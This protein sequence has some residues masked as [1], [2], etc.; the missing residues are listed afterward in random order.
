[1]PPSHRR[2]FSKEREKAKSR[3]DFQKHRERQQ[4]EEDLRG[5]L[6]W[7]TQ[8]EDLEADPTAPLVQAKKD[9][10]GGGAGAD[11]AGNN[12][13]G[14]GGGEGNASGGGNGANGSGGGPDSGSG[15]T[16]AAVIS[17]DPS[18]RAKATPVIM[19]LIRSSMIPVHQV[20]QGRGDTESIGRLFFLHPLSLECLITRFSYVLLA[21]ARFVGVV[22]SLTTVP[23]M[24]L[25]RL[26]WNLF[27]FLESCQC[28]CKMILCLTRMSS[29]HCILFYVR[30]CHSVPHKTL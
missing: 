10:N 12:N 27:E 13:N 21:L 9:G 1:M 20:M 8:A 2:E 24:I 16:G 4:L 30:A 14:G 19:G 6:D 7:I 18:A 15:P 22:Q 28:L 23:V 26:F 29:T 25:R 17:L 3:G 5:Y 11:A